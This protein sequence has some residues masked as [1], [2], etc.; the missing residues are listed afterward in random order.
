MR[1]RS[2]P[3]EEGY[4]PMVCKDD[5]F[6]IY[7]DGVNVTK[8]YLINTVDDNENWIGIYVT[9]DKKQVMMNEYNEPITDVIYGNVE[10][11]FKK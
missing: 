4:N 10:I 5:V 9:D 1:I 2:I 6:Q 3:D 11:K 8:K 7:L